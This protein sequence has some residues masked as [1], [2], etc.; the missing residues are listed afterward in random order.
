MILYQSKQNIHY[1]KHDQEN[2]CTNFTN[3]TQMYE[4]WYFIE[5]C[6][7]KSVYS[8]YKKLLK[9][10]TLKS[11]SYSD[12]DSELEEDEINST[13]DLVGFGNL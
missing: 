1:N 3:W 5:A 9:Q 2:N 12:S 4:K 7:T 13:P 8:W 10:N 6:I 11:E